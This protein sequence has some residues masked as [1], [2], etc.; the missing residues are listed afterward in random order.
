MVVAASTKSF[1]ICSIK[2]YFTSTLQIDYFSRFDVIHLAWL[3]FVKLPGINSSVKLVLL[4][5][6]TQ[7]VNDIASPLKFIICQVL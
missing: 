1:I 7:I 3:T 2:V 5:N 6:F 4:F